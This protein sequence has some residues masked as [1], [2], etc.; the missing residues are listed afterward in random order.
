MV[1]IAVARPIYLTQ[2]LVHQLMC[3]ATHPVV[4]GYDIGA[5]DVKATLLEINSWFRNSGRFPHV[6]SMSEAELKA[7]YGAAQRNFAG[8]GTS[9]VGMGR[10]VPSKLAPLHWLAT[11][12]YEYMWLLEDD[13]WSRD[14]GAFSRKFENS[15]ADLIA[16]SSSSDLPFWYQ[17]N[18]N[19][20]A[21]RHGLPKGKTCCPV[22]QLIALHANR[23]LLMS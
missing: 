14:F 13:V 18:W 3:T 10:A 9:H 15:T 12:Q 22:C 1:Y 11:S 16:R 4:V 7:S 5:E 17:D 20:G 2:L 21:Q 23:A 8:S 19:V 6:H